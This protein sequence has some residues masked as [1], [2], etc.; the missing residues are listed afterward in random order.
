MRPILPMAAAAA[1]LVG[2]GG[3]ASS[4]FE[5]ER[6]ARIL[7]VLPAPYNTADPVNG[8]NVFTLASACHTTEE[9]G[10]HMVGPN[11]HGV[12]G[13]QAGIKPESAYSDVLSNAGWTWDPER[14]DLW[15]AL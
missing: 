4:E 1:L 11:L 6:M 15:L 7:A 3:P 2:C 10:A 8:K 12:F 9:G 14:L 13:S 5:P